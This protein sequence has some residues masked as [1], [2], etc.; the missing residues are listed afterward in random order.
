MTLLTDMPEIARGLDE[1]ARCPLVGGF[2]RRRDLMH[3]PRFTAGYPGLV[4]I[5]QGQQISSVLA[6]RFWERLATAAGGEDAVTP[7]FFCRCDP[8]LLRSLG[9]TGRK[10]ES[11]RSLADRVAQGDFAITSLHQAK[12]T[13]LDA[14][15][16]AQKGFG[17]W[18]AHM[19]RLFCL[20]RPNVLP[21]SD[22]VVDRG[23][24]RIFKSKERPD[25][26]TLQT[27]CARWHGNWSALTL[28][29]WAQELSLRE[30][31]P[32]KARTASGGAGL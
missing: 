22:L 9:F 6:D 29:L 3:W 30:C 1:L 32:R 14:M 23:V 28:T 13:T 31:K 26:P 4:R 5:V 8:E 27:L 25:Y 19:Y 15:I 11:L 12:D 17:P 7:D 18:S 10:I 16:I 24:M 21:R 20:A 2:A